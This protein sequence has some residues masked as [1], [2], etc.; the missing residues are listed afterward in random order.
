MDTIEK[1]NLLVQK[2][3]MVPSTAK[4][5]VESNGKCVYCGIDVVSDRYLYATSEID[6]L[7]PRAR[8]KDLEEHPKN[9]VLACY[10]CNG[11]KQK[12]DPMKL[13]IASGKKVE[14]ILNDD[15]LREKVIDAIR[16]EKSLSE[17]ET[18]NKVKKSH[19][20]FDQVKA[21]I[22]G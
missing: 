10:C 9:I 16:K 14:E 12:F 6:H 22:K 17:S 1:I 2:K 18:N 11:K 5:Y 8:Y 21:I 3:L 4:V 15:Q 7:F 19:T 20:D 13:P